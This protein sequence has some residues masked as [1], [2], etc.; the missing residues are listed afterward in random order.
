MTGKELGLTAAIVCSIAWSAHARLEPAVDSEQSSPTSEGDQA[1]RIKEQA[2]DKFTPFSSDQEVSK[3]F[4]V[5]F[6][7]DI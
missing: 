6:P 3:D 4:P 7:T 2:V 5:L 1:P